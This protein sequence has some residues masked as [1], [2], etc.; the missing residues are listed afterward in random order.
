[1]GA[2]GRDDQDRDEAARLALGCW[3]RREQQQPGHAGDD[4][5]GRLPRQRARQRHAHDQGGAGGRAAARRCGALLGVALPVPVAVCGHHGGRCAPDADDCARCRPGDCEAHAGCRA[6][7]GCAAAPRPQQL[8]RAVAGPAFRE[9]VPSGVV[10]DGPLPFARAVPAHAADVAAAVLGRAG[11]DG[12]GEAEPRDGGDG[13]AGRRWGRR[14]RC[15]RRERHGAGRRPGFRSRQGPCHAPEA[16]PR[17]RGPRVC[18]QGRG[19][20]RRPRAHQ[21]GE[22]VLVLW[23]DSDGRAQHRPE[24][25]GRSR[26]GAAEGRRDERHGRIGHDGFDVRVAR[27]LEGGELCC[28]LPHD[29]ERPPVAGLDLEHADARRAARRHR[30]GA[31]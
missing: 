24:P 31:A 4:G 27:R 11:A 13:G 28:L 10:G 19:Q 14:G 25:G 12:G 20:G 16:P 1:M 15:W 7:R 3:R 2:A 9:Q 26:R 30:G 17:R 29:L 18:Q 8:V 22:R 23:Q 5:D 6:E 21:G